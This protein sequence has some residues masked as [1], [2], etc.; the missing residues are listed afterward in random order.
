MNTDDPII[1][2]IEVHWRA[3]AE[4]C[5]AYEQWMIYGN[6]RAQFYGT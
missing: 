5:A 4:T 1:A 2:A 3:C 6:L